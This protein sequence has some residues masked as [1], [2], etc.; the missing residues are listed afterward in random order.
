MTNTPQLRALGEAL[1]MEAIGI[2]LSKPCDAATIRWIEEAFAEHPVLVFRNQDLDAAALYDFA[3]HFGVPQKHILERYRHP[4]RPEISF[5][6]NVKEGRIDYVANKRATAWHA[7]ET[8]NA[9]LP[10]LAI[11][12]A[13]E[14]TS[15]GGGTMFADMRAAYDALPAVMKQKLAGRA[16]THGY[17]AGPARSDEFFKATQN[18]AK[19]A[20]RRHPAVLQHPVTRRPLLFVNPSHQTGFVGMEPEA[21]LQLVKDLGAFATQDRFTYYHRWQVGDLLMWDE[22]ATMH[23]GAGDAPPD[24]RRVML[25]TIVHP[26]RQ[27]VA[28]AA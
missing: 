6:S 2:D 23:R 27:P 12:H 11:L 21:G 18:E 15:A 1:G 8:Y 17:L 7:D 3:R 20:E 25:R 22:L 13:K 10:K 9:V 16:G 19:G 24:D 26:E 4:A 28:Y 5:V 14:V